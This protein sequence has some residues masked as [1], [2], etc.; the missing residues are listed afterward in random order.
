MTG[1]NLRRMNNIHDQFHEYRKVF[2]F[3]LSEVQSMVM[4]FGFGFGLGKI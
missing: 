3:L 1:K 4:L 2:F